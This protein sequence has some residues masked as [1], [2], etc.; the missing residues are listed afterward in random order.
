MKNLTLGV[1]ALLS[2]QLSV[3]A[4]YSMTV[5]STPAVGAGGTVYRFYVNMSDPTDRMSAVF[6]ND[7]SQTCT[8]T[9]R[10]GYLTVHTILHGM[11]PE[12]IQLSWLCFPIWLMTLTRP[13]VWNPLRRFLVLQGQL[14]LP[15]WRTAA[16]PLRHIF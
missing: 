8:S 16:S 3:V 11:L 12:S 1:L 9:P 2:F 6:G 13:L 10:K 4:Q 15:L 14:I 7:Q 5:E